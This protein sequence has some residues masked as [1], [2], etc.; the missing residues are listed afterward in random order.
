[1][2]AAIL[3]VGIGGIALVTQRVITQY[4]VAQVDAQLANT[5]G[6]GS[7]LAE[8]TG[9]ASSPTDYYLS[10]HFPHADTPPITSA[11]PATLAQHGTPRL[12]DLADTSLG[13]PFTVT[14]SGGS[15]RTQWRVLVQRITLDVDGGDD[16]P[17]VPA[18]AVVTVAL[19]LT[20]V[21]QAGRMLSRTLT[22]TSLL[23]IAAG[24]VAA[25]RLVR[26][27]LRPLRQIE[28]TAA[29]IA[30]GDLSRRAPVAPASTEVG[31]LSASLNTMLAQIEAAFAARAA[32]ESRTRMFAADASHE[33]RTP[34]ATLRGY[35]ELY[36]LGGVPA[37]AVPETM[38]RIEAAA[39][40]MGALVEGLLTLTRLDEHQALRADRVSLAGLADEAAHD[41]RALNPERG[42]TVLTTPTPA[43]IGDADRLRQV[44]TNLIGNVARHTPATSPVEIAAGSCAGGARA[45]IEVRDHGPGVA[46]EQLA[47][48]F[49]RF[50]R[51]D[52]SRT[53]Y[54]GGSGLG[55][56]IVAA[57]TA[58][59]GGQASTR[60]TPGG[61]LTVRVEL[62]ASTPPD[63]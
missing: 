37:E 31:S 6:D 52:A 60:Q 23:V 10:V 63:A 11:W 3:L 4:F 41:L 26:R 5:V 29:E 47:H 16:A 12:P 18:E 53:R 13:E 59:H 20:S 40:R 49:E 61:G 44:V 43:V 62:P 7:A 30:A 46:P 25:H 35:A 19:P 24:A 15:E 58:A 45:W 34:L 17:E 14:A 1:M 8:M 33:L 21:R 32:S 54:S 22:M 28:V 39:A 50:Y 36:R 56:A 27:S 9:P 51:A 55:L 2:F 57:I 42:V 48:L 38:D